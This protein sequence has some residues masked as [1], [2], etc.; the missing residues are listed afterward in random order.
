MIF[1]KKIGRNRL[2]RVF[3]DE[4]ELAVSDDLSEAIETYQWHDSLSMEQMEALGLTV[5]DLAKEYDT[6]IDSFGGEDAEAAFASFLKNQDISEEHLSAFIQGTD[7]FKQSLSSL[8][9][10]SSDVATVLFDQY[11]ALKDLNDE[12]LK[13]EGYTREQVEALHELAQA[14]ARGDENAEQM[15]EDMINGGTVIENIMGG[16]KGIFEGIKPVI[17]AIANAFKDI[18]GSKNRKS[19]REITKRFKEFGE[20]F[21]EKLA[22]N[23]DKIGRAF[24]GLFAILDLLSELVKGAL[25]LAF[26]VLGAIFGSTA[27]GVLDLAANTGDLLTNFHD[28]VLEGGYIEKV[29]DKIADVLVSLIDK[30]KSVVKWFKNLTGLD[31]ETIKDNISSLGSTIKGFFDSLD[32]KTPLK[33]IFEPFNK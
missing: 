14:F 9:M 3:R 10:E 6:L 16:L 29:F 25:T 30:I 32:F 17:K 12:Q 27:G 2:N 31:F 26:K 22:K 23:A 33:D 21:G 13:A 20:E 18:F 8:G 15:L 28:M 5:D 4:A 24:S 19:L 7:A 11:Y 1:A